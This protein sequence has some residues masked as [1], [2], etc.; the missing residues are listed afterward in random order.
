MSDDLVRDEVDIKREQTYALRQSSLRAYR[1]ID[2]RPNNGLGLELLSGKTVEYSPHEC[3]RAL[4]VLGCVEVFG[5]KGGVFD[6]T[7]SNE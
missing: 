4:E 7:T 6:H 2:R 3:V 1:E 5:Y